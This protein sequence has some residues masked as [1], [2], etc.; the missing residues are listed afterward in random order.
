[1]LKI[2]SMVFVALSISLFANAGEPKECT[3]KEASLAESD[4]DN[5]KDWDS[6]Y[7]SFKR[8]RHCDSGAVS[9]GYSAVI[10]HLLADDWKHI[11]RLIKLCSM[12]KRFERFVIDHIDETVSVNVSQQIID[13]TRLLCPS[14]AK[15]LCKEIE[16][17]ASEGWEPEKK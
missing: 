11:D 14:E 10:G 2:I 12:N 15:A 13:N 8:F 1:M 4:I 16:N 6:V 17:A 3:H 7:R 9:E 5:L